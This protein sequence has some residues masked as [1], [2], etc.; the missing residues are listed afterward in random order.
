MRGN[1]ETR[2]LSISELG[3]HRD[4]AV[5]EWGRSGAEGAQAGREW[6]PFRQTHPGL[7]PSSLPSR[8]RTRPSLDTSARA[9]RMQT[10]SSTKGVTRKSTRATRG[11]SPHRPHGPPTSRSHLSDPS[12]PFRI[13]RFKTSSRL[14][15][16]HPRAKTS[17]DRSQYDPSCPLGGG[18]FPIVIRLLGVF[19]R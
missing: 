11:S 16:G 4:I 12:A 1:S 15:R 7:S 8:H 14:A 19:R 17:Q 5:G 10:R 13:S 6:E 3:K 2:H 18:S 9:L